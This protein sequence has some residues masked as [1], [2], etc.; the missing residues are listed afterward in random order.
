[1]VLVWFGLYICP[2]KPKP[3]YENGWAK[4]KALPYYFFLSHSLNTKFEHKGMNMAAVNGARNELRRSCVQIC[5]QGKR[6]S[7]YDLFRNCFIFKE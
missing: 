5:V 3:I 1:L 6:K 7:S 2:D 4:E